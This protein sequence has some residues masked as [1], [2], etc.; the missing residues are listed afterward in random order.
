MNYLI[1]NWYLMELKINMRRDPLHWSEWSL[2]SLLMIKSE[3]TSVVTGHNAATFR[4][5]CWKVATLYFTKHV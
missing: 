1:P 4:V 5:H 2:V 3:W